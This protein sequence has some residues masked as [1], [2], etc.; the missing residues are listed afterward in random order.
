MNF[1]KMINLGLAT[2]P[3]SGFFSSS[4]KLIS[5]IRQRE[6]ETFFCKSGWF[7]RFRFTLFPSTGFFPYKN[8]SYFH[9]LQLQ[10]I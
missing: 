10:M 3:K 4:F 5:L 9:Q 1:L 8:R 2:I 6:R 7:I